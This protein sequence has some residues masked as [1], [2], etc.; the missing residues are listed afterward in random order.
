LKLYGPAGV[1]VLAVELG[2]MP[3]TTVTVETTVA[4]PAQVPPLNL[5][6]V[7]VPPAWKKLAI[8]EE[9]VTDEPAVI[10]VAESVVVI[11]G[12]ALLTVNTSQ[13]W[14]RAGLLLPSP[15]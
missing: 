7:T 5:L 1:G 8:V 13:V 4:V 15:L 12:L 2:T 6:Y 14:L 11:V 9:S 10:V 3:F